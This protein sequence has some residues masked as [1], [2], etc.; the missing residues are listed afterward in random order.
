MHLTIPDTLKFA[1]VVPSHKSGSKLDLNNY[2]PIFIL[3]PT[4][5]IF[6]TILH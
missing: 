1:K 2:R 4:N 3:S 5:K 6:E